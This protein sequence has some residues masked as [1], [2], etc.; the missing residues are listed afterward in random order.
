MRTF[1]YLERVVVLLVAST[2]VMA[3]Q[4]STAPH[5]EQSPERA[6]RAAKAAKAKKGKSGT[7]VSF[8]P[9]GKGGKSGKGKGGGVAVPVGACVFCGSSAAVG[10]KGG[11]V[12]LSGLTF[13]WTGDDVLTASAVEVGGGPTATI[14]DAALSLASGAKFPVNTI[15]TVDGITL[16]YH[17][18]CSK[19]LYVGQTLEF[20]TGTL[21]VTE[22][23]TTGGVTEADC[24]SLTTPVPTPA[25]P[26]CY[27][28]DPS[29]CGLPQCT[30]CGGYGYGKGKGAKLRE[31]TLRLDGGGA[32]VSNSQQGKATA[33]GGTIV[34]T[35]TVS[36][37]GAAAVSVPLGGTAS[38]S[39]SGANTWCT[40]V[41]VGPSGGPEQQ[42]AI[43]TSCSKE[44]NLGDRFGALV[45]SGFVRRTGET[46]A[47][48]CGAACPPC[49]GTPPPTPP[50]CY[51]TDP[52]TECPSCSAC[53][54][55]S[56]GGTGKGGGKGTHRHRR[57]AQLTLVLAGGAATQ[58]SN[59]QDGKA[60]VSGGTISGTA[61][62]GCNGGT[63][64]L[65]EIGG[66]VTVDLSRGPETTC[67]V[68]ELS[69]DGNRQTIDIHTSCSK[70]LSRY[71]QFGALVVVGFLL[72][73]G[74]S[75]VDQC[76]V[77]EPCLPTPTPAPT[78][79]LP[80][81]NCNNVD[82]NSNAF[83]CP[84]ST[85]FIDP[86]GACSNAAGGGCLV[87]ECCSATV[88]TP[89]PT[90]VLPVP[91]CNNVDGNLNA[92]QCPGTT[93]FRTPP[94][95]CSNTAGGGC[96]VAECCLSTPPP[97]VPLPTPTPPPASSCATFVCSAGY[98]SKAT[99][100]SIFCAA[101][102]GGVCTTA[103][104]CSIEYSCASTTGPFPPTTA[105]NCATVSTLLTNRA[106]PAEIACP[107]IG[108]SAAVC[109]T[110]AT[111][112]AAHACA[113]HLTLIPGAGTVP[114]TAIVG[115]AVACNDATCCSDER[116][117]TCA[118]ATGPPSTDAYVCPAQ[119]TAKAAP[120]SIACPSTPPLVAS[121]TS[122]VDTTC[123][124]P[125]ANCGTNFN[126]ADPPGGAFTGCA[127]L[128]TNGI[129]RHD[130]DD[131]TCAAVPCTVAD[132]CVDCAAI[133]EATA[134]A[135]ATGLHGIRDKDSTA[136]NADGS[137]TSF[138]IVSVT[139][140]SDW[141]K[142]ASYHHP[143]YIG[144]LA[145]CEQY[146][147]GLNYVA[148]LTGVEKVQCTPWSSD[149]RVTAGGVAGQPAG[150]VRS[151]QFPQPGYALTVPGGAGVESSDPAN[152]NLAKAKLDALLTG[153]VT[154]TTAGVNT[155]T[156]PTVLCEPEFCPFIGG[157][158]CIVRLTSPV[159]PVLTGAGK[160]EF[161]MNLAWFQQ[162][163]NLVFEGFCDASDAP[164]CTD[165][166]TALY[167]SRSCNSDKGITQQDCELSVFMGGF[168]PRP[169]A[170]A[171]PWPS[172]SSTFVARTG[173]FGQNEPTFENMVSASFVGDRAGNFGRKMFLAKSTSSAGGFAW[174]QKDDDYQTGDDDFWNIDNANVDT[175][176]LDYSGCLENKNCNTQIQKQGRV[177]WSR[178]AGDVK[179]Y[180]ATIAGGFQTAFLSVAAS[181]SATAYVRNTPCFPHQLNGL[182]YWDEVCFGKVRAKQTDDGYLQDYAP[183][184]GAE[185]YSLSSGGT[186]THAPA[187]ITS[188]FRRNSASND[189]TDPENYVTGPVAQYLRVDNVLT[190]DQNSP[191]ATIKQH[192]WWVP[193][194]GS[195]TLWDYYLHEPQRWYNMEDKV[196][197]PAAGATVKF[198][199]SLP[200]YRWVDSATGADVKLD[201]AGTGCAVFW[202]NTG[203]TTWD[204]FEA[205]AAVCP[206]SPARPEPPTIYDLTSGGKW[207]R[208]VVAAGL[209]NENSLFQA[210]DY[211]GQNEDGGAHYTRTYA[212]PTVVQVDYWVSALLK[213]HTF[214][215]ANR[216]A[217]PPTAGQIQ[218]DGNRF[219]F[220]SAH[221]CL[222]DQ[223]V[224]ITEGGGGTDVLAA[225]NQG[226]FRIIEVDATKFEIAAFDGV[227]P[228]GIVGASVPL[229]AFASPTDT[230]DINVQCYRAGS[231]P[232]SWNIYTR[233]PQHTDLSVG[234]F[235]DGAD[236]FTF[237]G[238]GGTV[239]LGPLV[240]LAAY[241]RQNGA[242]ADSDWWA[243]QLNLAGTD[244]KW[245]R[246][247]TKPAYYL[248]DQGGT[249]TGSV[250]ATHTFVAGG[251]TP[252]CYQLTTPPSGL[253]AF[254]QSAGE[255]LLT[256]SVYQNAACSTLYSAGKGPLDTVKDKAWIHP[257]TGVL[258]WK[259]A[260]ETAFDTYTPTKKPQQDPGTLGWNVGAEFTQTVTGGTT[261]ILT[262]AGQVFTRTGTTPLQNAPAGT[263]KMDLDTGMLTVAMTRESIPPT[264]RFFFPGIDRIPSYS[265]PNSRSP[266]AMAFNTY[267]P[268]GRTHKA[269]MKPAE[270]KNPTAGT[271][272]VI[273]VDATTG[274][275]VG[276]PALYTP[277]PAGMPTL[278]TEAAQF[279]GTLTINAGISATTNQYVLTGDA[280]DAR[281]TGV[282]LTAAS[283]AMTGPSAKCANGNTM[284]LDPE[285]VPAGIPH[286][287]GPESAADT[288]ADA[289]TATTCGLSQSIGAEMWGF[290]SHKSL[291]RFSDQVRDEGWDMGCVR[292]EGAEQEDINTAKT[293]AEARYTPDP[294]TGAYPNTDTARASAFANPAG[295]ANWFCA[296]ASGIAADNTACAA[297]AP[298]LSPSAS[299]LAIDGAVACGNTAG[300]VWTPPEAAEA[301]KYDRVCGWAK[302]KAA[303][304][305]LPKDGRFKK[306]NSAAVGR[307]T[308]CSCSRTSNYF[309]TGLYPLCEDAFVAG[310]PGSTY[311]DS[312]GP[313]QGFCGSDPASAFRT[314]QR[315]GTNEAGSNGRPS[316]TNANANA[317]EE[318]LLNLLYESEA[319][320]R[321]LEHG[322]DDDPLPVL[323][324][325]DEEFEY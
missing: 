158:A 66:L 67:T 188:T 277:N 39:V 187:G 65:V 246:F 79:V 253:P 76:G 290:A 148:L 308:R 245:Y 270:A 289:S 287:D 118:S 119:W 307:K 105:F 309:S 301:Q 69:A 231:V 239:A 313:S 27:D 273:E 34:S 4:V 177:E 144:T 24:P 180:P 323:A 234:T 43:H 71:D 176:I 230:A 276:T 106:L 217:A 56:G 40:V 129:L 305:C 208:K 78:P 175:S 293:L 183:P 77:C 70:D 6:G 9:P 125:N 201:P 53:G 216:V 52:A 195:A 133:T 236:P 211:N 164:M 267:P 143:L 131:I 114:C 127:G 178:N 220:G 232:H 281:L 102:A 81:P 36:C 320:A 8:G 226:T 173:N 311:R 20:G 37:N 225:A 100:A 7:I 241:V 202:L 87:A 300:C 139:G 304:T 215:T 235:S 122:C 260:T 268:T 203:V 152:C 299:N 123:C 130:K 50:P 110:S 134:T 209:A 224:T 205:R 243:K 297:A 168:G 228:F 48:V 55:G 54:T 83:Q 26:T 191:A 170:T 85:T 84:D 284:A 63:A 185:S 22:F 199:G 124:D 30:I 321:A 317:N 288:A 186:Y 92:F 44:L 113:A 261:T 150:S 116:A 315:R 193:R 207:I 279:T 159:N 15:I 107:T 137:A 19:P 254:F 171:T 21:T 179:L 111:T 190:N 136:T 266:L 240:G 103:L 74:W 237:V 115:G 104:C 251:T 17:T 146:V 227:T 262:G 51:S 172:A 275:Q 310:F 221:G 109:C 28:V 248:L 166:E 256:F 16:A 291:S 93:T 247:T 274:A 303:I 269:I 302:E 264:T 11:K 318:A 174:A 35:S 214:A 58:L 149:N 99:P 198:V 210:S 94:G 292:D 75:D 62:V 212:T 59:L 138:P 157:G 244:A 229:V 14:T 135:P 160:P 151:E 324:Y 306:D 242:L 165:A 1:C 238:V 145:E 153:V 286:P 120:G 314:V 12:K 126:G 197:A 101:G 29:E 200:K 72:D 41:Q 325:G 222:D 23:T 38:F 250:G 255:G 298:P 82:G 319:N 184:T 57:L 18:S 257:D 33:S 194:A 162:L 296:A 96:L 112:C 155:V 121:G 259:L 132:C 13:A 283:S 196:Y 223:L 278:E 189:A 181:S 46:E 258:S 91:N 316:N 154:K 32:T 312:T 31:I 285:R 219:V 64:T 182:D 128:G 80:V 68:A 213:S 45:V 233:P 252:A 249:W 90:P 163:N 10:S 167:D 169:A 117:Q 95:A 272:E 3:G 140:G 89:A 282:T 147:A 156:T 294:A 108:C 2:I 60:S 47:N 322:D 263:A 86:P 141:G 42:L 49:A 142:S 61:L 265:N 206:V 98:T 280:N 88:P 97:P 204:V 218:I 161:I 271:I 192:D 5:V 25:P 73:T 295:T